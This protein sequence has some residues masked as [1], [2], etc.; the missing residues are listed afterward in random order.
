MCLAS[1]LARGAGLAFALWA[2]ASA[3]PLLTVAA[4]AQDVFAGQSR[5]FDEQFS[6]QP[7]Q[8]PRLA[9]IAAQEDATPYLDQPNGP[10]AGLARQQGYHTVACAHAPGIVILTP[11]AAKPQI[12]AAILKLQTQR[13]A[14]TSPATNPGQFDCATTEAQFLDQCLKSEGW[15]NA[16]VYVARCQQAYQYAESVNKRACPVKAGG[17]RLAPLKPQL[18]HSLDQV[19]GSAGPCPDAPPGQAPAEGQ[20]F[21]PAPRIGVGDEGPAAVAPDG[22]CYYRGEPLTGGTKTYTAIT[23]ADQRYYIDDAQPYYVGKLSF[24][25]ISQS[26]IPFFINPK[27]QAIVLNQERT[28]HYDSNDRTIKLGS[29]GERLNNFKPFNA[30]RGK[31]T[32]IQSKMIDGR[33]VL[34]GVKFEVTGL[35]AKNGGPFI[36][37]QSMSDAVYFLFPSTTTSF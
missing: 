32:Q 17:S 27:H 13:A 6:A 5:S 16:G 7:C 22:H 11:N 15:P 24:P 23:V 10:L 19:P 14:P 3:A 29:N 36:R 18:D 9:A 20:S 4:L 26:L 34:T 2:I 21:K 30:I 12:K 8:D 31:I 33:S 25:K 1:W 37:P 28:I 35:Q